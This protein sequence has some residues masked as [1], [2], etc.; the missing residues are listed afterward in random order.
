MKIPT[1]TMGKVYLVGAGPSDAGLITVKGRQ[2]IEQAQV[3]IY[4]ALI[5]YGI[6]T[7]FP[8]QAEMISVGKRAGTHSAKQ[9]EIN[10]LL[11]EKA[12]EGKRVVRVK[13]GDPFLFGRGGEELELLV[14]HQIP[15]EVVPGVTS[16]LA[17]AAYAGIPV[18]YRGITDSVHI[19]TGHK[20]Q[21]EPL[22][23]DFTALLKTKGTYLFLMGVSAIHEIVQ[24]FL[25]AGMSPDMP[26]A[27]LQNGTNADC[28]NVFADLA[29]LEDELHKRQ[30]KTPAVIV[31]GE[32]AAL[33]KKFSWYDQLPLSK[34]RI[35]ITRPSA[36]S[37]QMA[38]LLYS[39]GAEVL[40]MPT[41]RTQIRDCEKQFLEVL[42]QINE[43]HYLVFTSP[44]GVDYFFELLDRLELDIRCIGTIR[45]AVIGSATAKALKK[46]GLR[47]ALMPE[48]Y[49][50]TA[51]GKLLNEVVQE[52][53]KVLIL[54]SSMGNEQLVSE[55]QKKKQIEVLDFA[56]YETVY[57]QDIN[58]EMLTEVKMLLETGRIE[59]VM[60][61]SASTVCGF[62]R[63]LEGV[64]CTKIRAVC[65][66]QM[67]AE[68]AAGYGMQVF[69]AQ[70]ETIE[71][72]VDTAVL[73]HQ[74]LKK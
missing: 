60:F 31:I 5:G 58:K 72:M 19:I 39:L 63:L 32:V 4:D 61:T 28:Q 20:K 15:Y 8:Q 51:L 34:S 47:P 25:C 3:I 13:G 6:R 70:M 26:A 56:L 68:Q 9:E 2:V 40:Q 27:V 45:L 50:G 29:S 54:R 24:G 17:V 38:E 41:I 22:D 36:R 23:I 7:L 55:I 30:V 69:Q 73:L 35:L 71:S 33:G 1:H 44:A 59:M 37:V 43:Y 57:Q 11:V 53:E 52:G 74:H 42:S 48:R 21:N 67:T 46:R 62:M 10:R 18:T 66:G 14:T 49:H 12:L 64:D 16:A 65:I